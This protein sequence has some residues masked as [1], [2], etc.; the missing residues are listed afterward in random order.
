MGKI[1]VLFIASS[2][3]SGTTLLDRLLGQ[4]N[5]LFSAGELR[6]IWERGFKENQLCG[7][8]KSFKECDVWQQVIKNAFNNPLIIYENIDEIIKL[9]YSVD[10]IRY[11]PFLRYEKFSDNLKIFCEEYI[12]PLYSSIL[13]AT[14]K[15]IIVDSSKLPSY[16]YILSKC[17]F[18]DLYVIHMIRDSRAVAYSQ[19][20]KKLRPEIIDRREYMPR[21]SPIKSS[22]DWI[23][24][25]LL[26]SKIKNHIGQNRYIQVRY[27]DMAKNPEKTLKDV[28]SSLNTKDNLSFFIKNNKANLKPNHTVSGNPMRFKTGII[29]IKLDDEWKERLTWMNRLIVSLI[30][31]PLMRKFYPEIYKRISPKELE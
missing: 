25:N 7:C 21:Y 27:E 20:K 28:L 1:K 26:I 30:T 2:G 3:R 15:K 17:D 23:V 19:S 5:D 12:Y 6:Y 9:Q 16:L 8:N 10:R 11:I 14:D 31:Y 24:F 22:I 18:I 4:I 29:D 13:K